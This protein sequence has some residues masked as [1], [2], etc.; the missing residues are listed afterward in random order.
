[1]QQLTHMFFPL[2]LPTPPV[3]PGAASAGPI[4]TPSRS[5]LN[6]QL[7]FIPSGCPLTVSVSADESQPS[8]FQDAP[9]IRGSVT[10]SNP[11]SYNVPITNIIVQARSSD[12]MLYSTLAYCDGNGSPT[13]PYNPVPYTYGQLNCRYRLVLD[14]NVFGSY[15][16]SGNRKL[17]SGGQV[18]ANFFPGSSGGSSVG[19]FPP[20]S[21]RASWT[22]TAIVTVR[23]SN[24]QCLSAPTPVN[25]D[26]WWNWLA[27][28]HQQHHHKLSW[29][30]GG[31]K[32]LMNL[33]GSV[34][35]QVGLQAGTWSAACRELRRLGCRVHCW[36]QQAH[37]GLAAPC[38]SVLMLTVCSQ[39]SLS[40]LLRFPVMLQVAPKQ[41]VG[42]STVSRTLL[43]SHSEHPGN[44]ASEH[45]E[46]RHHNHHHNHHHSISSSDGSFSGSGDSSRSLLHSQSEHFSDSGLEHSEHRHHNHHHNHHHSISSGGGSGYR[47]RSLLHASFGGNRGLT[48][49]LDGSGD[50]VAAI[51]ATAD[52]INKDVDSLSS[53]AADN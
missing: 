30:F 10:L 23:F 49:E 39:P 9:E 3:T 48:R 18:Q 4:S 41:A 2:R 50:R 46:H 51:G 19:Y 29:L 26:C 52:D 35:A 17:L 15:G 34:N 27:S 16:Q 38:C 21:Q 14:R 32:L 11:T 13:V 43:S 28:W 36:V 20:P 42:D 8:W 24:A 37:C 45:S 33:F 6:S 12:G 7:G 31:R 25:T 44:S 1:M 5:L 47:S 40:V 22:V 53:D